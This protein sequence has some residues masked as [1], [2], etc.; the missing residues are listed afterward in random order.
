[1]L[2]L[3]VAIFDN[4]RGKYMHFTKRKLSNPFERFYA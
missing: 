2:M 4:F 3:F 1:M